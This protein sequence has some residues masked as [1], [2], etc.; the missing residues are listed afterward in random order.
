M[1]YRSFDHL[2]ADTQEWIV[3]L[4]DGLDLIVEYPEVAC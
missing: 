4:P 3:D 1:N 2:S